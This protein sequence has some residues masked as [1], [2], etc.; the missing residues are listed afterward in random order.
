M[1]RGRQTKPDR[2]ILLHKLETV[3]EG[4]SITA[5]WASRPGKDHFCKGNKAVEPA[6]ATLTPDSAASSFWREFGLARR[7]LPVPGAQQCR[8]W[9]GQQA[10]GAVECADLLC[11]RG[12]AH[13]KC[14][15][16]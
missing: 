7:S 13:A 2:P 3:E 1:G 9:K 12:W 4:L 10:S 14:S 6:R 15:R 11:D 8:V 16:K 5:L